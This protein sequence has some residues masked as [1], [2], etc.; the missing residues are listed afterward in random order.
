MGAVVVVALLLVL[1]VGAGVLVY[2]GTIGSRPY[3]GSIKGALGL[4]SVLGLLLGLSVALA[5]LVA[6][7]AVRAAK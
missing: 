2:R 4:A 7:L 1:C 3:S 6:V 5:T